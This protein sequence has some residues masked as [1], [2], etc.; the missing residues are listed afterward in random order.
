M[1]LGAD[2]DILG[3]DKISCPCQDSSHGLSSLQLGHYT[4]HAIPVIC[5]IT[6]VITELVFL[7][8]IFRYFLLLFTFILL[9]QRG[10]VPCY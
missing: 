2:L 5:K 3:V 9:H 8:H 6:V 4:D 7:L 1:G 10:L